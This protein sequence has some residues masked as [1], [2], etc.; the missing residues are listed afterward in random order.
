MTLHADARRT[1]PL[2]AT[3]ATDLASVRAGWSAVALRSENLFATWEWADVWWRHFGGGDRLRIVMCRDARGAVRAVVPLCLGALGPLRLLRFVGHG[4]ADE[5][6]PICAVE[7]R[8]LAPHALELALAA[9]PDRWD[10]LLG[11]RLRGTERWDAV[12]GARRVLREATPVVGLGGRTWE[13]WLATRTY[14]RRRQIRYAA[15]RLAREHDVRFRLCATDAE[16]PSDMNT[17]CVLHEARWGEEGSGALRG[18]RRRFHEE[19]AAVALARGWLRLWT[20]ELDGRRVAA[21]YGFRF[22]GSDYDY[23]AGRDPSFDAHSI[24]SVLEMHVL[25]DAAEAGMREYRMLRGD[26]QYKRHFA[27]HDPGLDTILVPGTTTGRL[28]GRAA[29][30]SQRAR[31]EVRHALGRLLRRA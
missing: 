16:L 14:N 15:R 30:A 11:E 28:A 19:W 3:V 25:R 17:L 21:F 23:Q 31:P 18:A 6:G 7:D 4:P 24:G 13:E 10:L 27:D 5:L 20:M 9:V 1:E 8:H 12:P 26:E 22:G 29:L 2:Q